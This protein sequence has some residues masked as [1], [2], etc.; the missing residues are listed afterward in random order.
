MQYRLLHRTA[1]NMASSKVSDLGNGEWSSNKITRME[2]SVFCNLI[3]DLPF[4]LSY[5][6]GHTHQMKHSVN[7][8]ECE[9]QKVGIIRDYLGV[10]LPQ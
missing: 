5:A 7:S 4:L 9:Y 8:Q 1:H 3:L 2:A 6:I 10:W